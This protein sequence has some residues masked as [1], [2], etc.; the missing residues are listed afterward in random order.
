MP[1]VK[2]CLNSDNQHYGWRFDCPGCGRCHVIPTE[3]GHGKDPHH[4]WTFNNNVDR[5][6]FQPSLRVSWTE[7]EQQVKH[8]CHSIITDGRIQFCADCT[9]KLAGQTVDLPEI[10]LLP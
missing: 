10:H 8:V 2:H 4:N 3:G 6:T 5:P 7:G 9:H 1:R